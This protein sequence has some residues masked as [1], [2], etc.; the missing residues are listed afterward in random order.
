M[1]VYHH[2]VRKREE[3]VLYDSKIKTFKE[4]LIKEKKLIDVEMDSNFFFKFPATTFPQYSNEFDILSKN[5]REK[6]REE[7]ITFEMENGK[8]NEL[9]N[10]RKIRKIIYDKL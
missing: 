4:K 8:E 6:E 9:I 2:S 3:L 5:K 7:N 1:T 10:C